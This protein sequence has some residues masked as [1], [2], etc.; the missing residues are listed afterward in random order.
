MPAPHADY[1]H[2]H[3]DNGHH[4]QRQQQVDAASVT[5]RALGK[6]VRER[7]S[8]VRSGGEVPFRQPLLAAGRRNSPG[9]LVFPAHLI[10][11]LVSR[12]FARRQ[13]RPD[14]AEVPGS[15]PGSLIPLEVSAV[16]TR[17]N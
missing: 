16:Q 1:G 7:A 8:I 14:K 11:T 6:Y 2:A 10:L 5:A 17:E 9:L 13:E 15:N 4:G 3:H 12:G